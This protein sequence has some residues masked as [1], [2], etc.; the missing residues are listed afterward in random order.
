MVIYVDGWTI[1]IDYYGVLCGGYGLGDRPDHAGYKDI[2][3]PG[4]KNWDALFSSVHRSVYE[5]FI[6]AAKG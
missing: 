6:Q 5:I 1:L 2:T 3:I 4:W